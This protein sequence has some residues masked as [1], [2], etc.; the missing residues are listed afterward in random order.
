[1]RVVVVVVVVVVAARRAALF[2]VAVARLRDGELE[3][4]GFGIGRGPEH[5]RVRAEPSPEINCLDGLLTCPSLL[6]RHLV[7][8]A[9]QH[10]LH[11]A[12]FGLVS[13]RVGGRGRAWPGDVAAAAAT[14]QAR[15]RAIS[16]M[17]EREREY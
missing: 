4:V 11:A 16:F 7:L 3:A 2:L 5:G 14:R 17:T 8:A 13:E 12:D 9:P 1:M 15:S 6:D 10:R